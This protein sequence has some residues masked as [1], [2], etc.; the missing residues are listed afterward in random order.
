MTGEKRN[1]YR[2]LVR[3]PEAKRPLGRPRHRQVNNI[4]VDLGEME[5]GGMNWT[6]LAQVRDQWKVLVY[7]VMNLQVPYSIEKF[8]R[9]C[10]TD[11]FSRRTHLHEVN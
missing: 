4:K 11:D 10:T 3:K 1:V 8:L 7:M 9:S 2:I 5:W 6:D